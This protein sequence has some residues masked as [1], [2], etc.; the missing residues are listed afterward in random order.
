MPRIAVI[1][2]KKDDLIWCPQSRAWVDKK[3]ETAQFDWICDGFDAMKDMPREDNPRLKIMSY[4]V[5]G[6]EEYFEVPVNTP[7]EMAAFFKK[8][9][10]V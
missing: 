8:Y 7:E 4:D 2:R 9:L 6:R 1:V 3:T 5:A 10:G